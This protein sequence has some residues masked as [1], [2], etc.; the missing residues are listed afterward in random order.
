M[1]TSKTTSIGS[2]LIS[3]AKWS[4]AFDARISFVKSTCSHQRSSALSID[5]DLP[6]SGVSIFIRH[7]DDGTST[8]NNHITANNQ[9]MRSMYLFE[10][11]LL[12]AKNVYSS[13]MNSIEIIRPVR[14]HA[15]G[16]RLTHLRSHTL[17]HTV[18]VLHIHTTLAISLFL[19]TKVTKNCYHQMCFLGSAKC[20]GGRG[21]APDPAWVSLERSPRLL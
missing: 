16:V 3:S 2:N 19:Q 9:E 21:S 5:I 7:T 10:F 15:L 20:V 18:E 1:L 12:N 17:K 11:L 4:S 13:Q 6:S 8:D 14:F